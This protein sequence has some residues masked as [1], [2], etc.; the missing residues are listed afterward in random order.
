MKSVKASN[1]NAASLDGNEKVRDSNVTA[2]CE[3]TVKRARRRIHVPKT[4]TKFSKLRAS[5]F[6]VRIDSNETMPGFSEKIRDVGVVT[7]AAGGN[8]PALSSTDIVLEKRSCMR[9]C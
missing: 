1:R 8:Q 3:R 5:K 9:L 2:T 4:A 6:E 7:L